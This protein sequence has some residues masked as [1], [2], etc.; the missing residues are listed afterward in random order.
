MIGIVDY[1][2]GNI[3]SV[4]NALTTIGSEFVVSADPSVLLRCAGV[5][6]PGVGAAPGAMAALKR[7][8]LIEFLSH[9]TQ[10]VLGICLGMQLLFQF[11]E[12]G[13]TT[14]LGVFPGTVKKFDDSKQKVP[15]MGWNEVRCT[16]NTMLMNGSREKEYYYF[17]HS[18]FAELD[19]VTVATSSLDTLFAA[20]VARDNYFG[21]QFHPEKSGD[22]GLAILHNFDTLCK[23]F[24]Q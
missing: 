22:A 8:G 10:P 11:S 24:R 1:E 14:C 3:S 23:S 18:Y 7:R 4:S 9:S 20:V 5:I 21:V 6:L 19:A 13:G 16:G 12:E 2:A 17:A 15:H